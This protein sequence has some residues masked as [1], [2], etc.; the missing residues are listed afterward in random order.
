MLSELYFWA[1]TTD[2]FQ[3]QLVYLL[4]SL[5]IQHELAAI[6]IIEK[7]QSFHAQMQNFLWFQLLY[8]LPFFVLCDSKLNIFGFRLLDEQNKH[9]EDMIKISENSKNHFG[10]IND[11]IAEIIFFQLT[12]K[13]STLPNLSSCPLFSSSGQ[14]LSQEIKSFIS[15]VDTIQGRKLSVREHA[16]CAVR[17]LRSVPACRGAVLEH[18]RGV[19][20]EHV[21]AFLHNLETEGDANS[22]VSSNLEDIIQVS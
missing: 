22:A 6:L 17:L 1:A 21:S 15:G 13:L 14:E 5:S 11:V 18:L 16:R 20:D 10:L 2:Y 19:Y 12:I 4:I 7:V 9:L 8:L 3:R